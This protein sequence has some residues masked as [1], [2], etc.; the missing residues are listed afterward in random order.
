MMKIIVEY[1]QLVISQYAHN[2]VNNGRSHTTLTL[3]SWVYAYTISVKLGRKKTIV[4]CLSHG[5]RLRNKDNISFFLFI[6]FTIYLL[7]YSDLAA[8]KH[9]DQSISHPNLKQ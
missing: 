3:L 1:T 7:Q 5:R 8:N 4:R 9:T 2:A 6:S